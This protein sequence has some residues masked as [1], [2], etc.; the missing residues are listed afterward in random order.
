MLKYMNSQLIH[1]TGNLFGQYRDEICST[2][3][4]EYAIKMMTLSNWLD[5]K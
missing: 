5:K 3:L 1:K 4:N 2:L